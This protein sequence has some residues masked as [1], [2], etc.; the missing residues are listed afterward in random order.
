MLK[1][2]CHQR[3]SG[4]SRSSPAR[5]FY[6]DSNTM[7]STRQPSCS[8]TQRRSGWS[9]PRDLGPSRELRINDTILISVNRSGRHLGRPVKID[10]EE[11]SASQSLV[12]ASLTARAVCSMLLASGSEAS[13][14]IEPEDQ[15]PPPRPP[16]KRPIEDPDSLLEAVRSTWDAEHPG[17]CPKDAMFSVTTDIPASGIEILIIDLSRSHPSP[18]RSCWTRPHG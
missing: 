9:P 2:G 3:P 8:N 11:V 14:P 10:L 1:D 12:E 13:V 6:L 17:T 7:L 15:G 18:R 5:T 16:S 4:D